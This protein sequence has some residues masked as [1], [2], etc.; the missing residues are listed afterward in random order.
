MHINF[1]FLRV[2]TIFFLGCSSQAAV[3]ESCSFFDTKIRFSKD[4]K[5]CINSK[6]L[7]FN[8]RGLIPGDSRTYLEVIK[9]SRSYSV[10]V[11][12]DPMMC[13]FVT[14]IAYDWGGVVDA[15]KAIEFC[16]KKLNA[17]KSTICG[18]ETLLDSG[19]SLLNREQFDRRVGLLERQILGSRL[20]LSTPEEVRGSELIREDK[21]Q[22]DLS[23]TEERQRLAQ[24]RQRLLEKEKLLEAERLQR[25]QAKPSSKIAIE[26]SASKPSETGDFVITINTGS[27]TAS[28][29]IDGEEQGGRK[30]GT[31]S[32]NRLARVGQ[33]NTYT[34][35][36]RDVYGNT[37]SKKI[38]VT[39][40]PLESA[41]VSAKLNPSN[42]KLQP[43]REAVAII[44]GIANY[45]NLPKAEFASDDARVF[46]DYAQRALGVRPENIKLLVD[47]DADEIEIIRAFT[48]WLPTRAKKNVTDVYV[49]YSGHGLP[50]DDGKNLYLL[51]VR[52]DRDFLARTAILQ[53]ELNIYLEKVKPKSVT[54]FLD[55]CY[56]GLARTGEPLLANARPV[57]LKAVESAFPSNFTV[58]S[59]SQFDQ[60]SSSSL[61]LGHGIFSYYL[62]R[63]MEGDADGNKDGKI[64][65]GEMQEYLSDKVSRQA[66]SINRKQDT[67]LVGDPSRVLVGR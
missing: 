5:F 57:S 38:T 26:V 50:A 34:V 53:S 47:G 21:A 31:Y 10:A 2:L 67:Q 36:A 3:A 52:V 24:E 8:H 35:I 28:L 16:Q 46:Y 66:M 30:D 33:D 62:M 1:S 45:K 19:M 22:N 40:K 18:C 42:I 14:G 58:I 25:A 27:D 20:A 44:I 23:L 39:R 4:E 60:I 48:S 63:G 13:P 65:A 6:S 11:S 56:S 41:V 32:V 37:D 43:A 9:S 12:T 7:F 59:A 54:I 15:Q 61:E 51:P 55:S 29:K 64:T 17:E 49:F